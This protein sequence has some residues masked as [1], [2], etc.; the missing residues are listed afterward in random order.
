MVNQHPRK[1][2]LRKKGKTYIFETRTKGKS[3]YL[4]TI[5]QPYED[6]VK[7]LVKASFFPIGKST[8]I[9]R[10]IALSDYDPEKMQKNPSK[11]PIMNITRTSKKDENAIDDEINELVDR[12]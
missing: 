5:S 9:L 11:V 1:V 10:K 4:F 6:F 3:T 7:K 8:Q 2:Y 12:I